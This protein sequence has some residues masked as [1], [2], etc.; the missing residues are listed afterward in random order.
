[1]KPGEN[2]EILRPGSIPDYTYG[3]DMVK[4][5]I[6]RFPSDPGHLYRQSGFSGIDP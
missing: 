6:Q 2:T 1:M 4:I 3:P 5:E